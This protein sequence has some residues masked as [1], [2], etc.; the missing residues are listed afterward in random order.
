MSDAS[1]LDTKIVG[2]EDMWDNN[3]KEG[4]HHINS[5]HDQFT[6]W[7]MHKKSWD[8]DKQLTED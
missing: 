4:H 6:F 7:D 1:R 8:V 2:L 5:F 3:L